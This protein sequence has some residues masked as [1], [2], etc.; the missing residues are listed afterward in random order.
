MGADA[1]LASLRAAAAV[2]T[3]I[4]ADFTERQRAEG[5]VTVAELQA[6][7]ASP[8]TPV[9]HAAVRYRPSLL[10][11]LPPELLVAV[12]RLLDNRS[13][14]RFACTCS[15]MYMDR[16]RPM[17]PVE[18]ALRQCAAESA[19]S[20]PRTFPARFQGWVPFL[21]RRG[22]L[23][24]GQRSAAAGCDHSVVIDSDGRLLRCGGDPDGETTPRLFPTVHDV[25]FHS[26]SSSN[27][28][29]LALSEAGDVYSWGQARNAPYED[30][31]WAMHADPKIV[32]FP[33]AIS[34]RGISV[35]GY[36]C[37]AL[38]VD[39]ALFTWS[40]WVGGCVPFGLGDEVDRS[41][42][43]AMSP[44][45]VQGALD[46][47]RVRSVAAGFEYTLVATQEGELFSFGEGW[48]GCLGHGD[49]HGA[50]YIGDREDVHLPQRVEAL[51]P[52]RGQAVREVAAGQSCG[53]A[54]TTQGEVF[55]LDNFEC[56]RAEGALYG[57]RVAHISAG[58]SHLAAVNDAGELF[59]WGSD[60]R[61]G[62][63]GHGGSGW[64]QVAEPR[65]VKA[66]VGTE[67]AGVSAEDSQTFAV[68][69]DGTVYAFGFLGGGRE[70]LAPLESFHEHV[71]GT[72]S[73]GY[74]GRV[75]LPRHV[76][77]GLRLLL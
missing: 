49:S 18:E 29:S 31:D 11:C 23:A 3:R 7:F 72:A 15:L 69:R 17:T 62:C 38:T 9:R 40:C 46:G 57:A 32:P 20:I 30:E 53:M 26:V 2:C 24:E 21:L 58:T 45:R 33:H 10:D 5:L 12:L 74:D 34:V 52:A 1:A 47:V 60:Y 4:G 67:I 55:I 50:D 19:R 16:P 8:E 14:V 73:V 51:S 43:N 64:L 63:L 42:F 44:R 39:G 76:A 6:L 25:H 41:Q 37:A 13:L 65:R 75:S 70:V 59:T 66:L 61:S 77:A 27:W 54:L 56:G 22:G 28:V 48:C 71:N 68:A 36:H 35:G